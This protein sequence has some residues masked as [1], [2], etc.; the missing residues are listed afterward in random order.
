[1][2]GVAETQPEPFRERLR[3]DDSAA[4]IEGRQRDRS[5]GSLALIEKHGIP[6]GNRDTA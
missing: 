1:M 6:P 4:R 2:H 5:V 3:H